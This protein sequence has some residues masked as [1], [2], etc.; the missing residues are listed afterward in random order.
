[1]ADPKIVFAALPHVNAIWLT[2]D[3]HFHLHP[4]NGGEEVTRESLEVISKDD[5][6]FE[7]VP[8]EVPAEPKVAEIPSPVVPAEVPAEPKVSKP[9]PNNGRSKSK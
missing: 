6:D 9:R 2:E 7:K 1:M 3:G 8:A 4:H 5:E